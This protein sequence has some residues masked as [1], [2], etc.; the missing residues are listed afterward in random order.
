M[1]LQGVSIEEDL[2]IHSPPLENE[3]SVAVE[4]LD[5][6]PAD[7]EQIAL[8]YDQIRALFR[9][10]QKAVD[11]KLAS[12]FDGHLKTVMLNLSNALRS[13]EL[14]VKEKNAEVLKSKYFLY[15]VCFE[16]AIT[17]LTQQEHQPEG[18]RTS[19]ESAVF[20]Q[21][22]QGTCACF[23]YMSQQIAAPEQLQLDNRRLAR[24]NARLGAALAAK[25]RELAAGEERG[26]ALEATLQEFK[27]LQEQMEREFELQKEQM[28]RQIEQ[29]QSENQRCVERLLKSQKD[30]SALR[31]TLASE[32]RRISDLQAQL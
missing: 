14:T 26:R 24:D 23:V 6:N 29:L 19:Q 31:D 32:Q 20:D 2:S 25:E 28:A 11:K 16:K 21:I 3:E 22:R 5:L 9:T 13:Q 1:Q 17:Y 8:I 7:L 4:E 27:E 10:R 18:A 15:D 12:E 30:S